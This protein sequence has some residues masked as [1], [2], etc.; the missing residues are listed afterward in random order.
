MN[1]SKLT[2]KERNLIKGAIRRIFSRSDLRRKIV[3]KCVVEH[4]D[5]SRKRVKTWC[6][7]PVCKQYVAKS[8]IQVDHIEPVIKITES[9]EDLTWDELVDR[10]WCDEQN[11]MPIC[12]DCHKQKS[13]QEMKLRRAYK[14][15]KKK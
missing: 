5:P 10:I 3:Q 6:L 2:V 7:C 1:S 12:I 9:L 13:K 8:S 4:S 14:K 11:L 15:E